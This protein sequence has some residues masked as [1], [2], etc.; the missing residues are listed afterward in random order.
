[1][2]ENLNWG[3]TNR[4]LQDVN[5]ENFDDLAKNE[6]NILHQEVIQQIQK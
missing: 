1:M 3:L 4:I 5:A 2:E 6:G